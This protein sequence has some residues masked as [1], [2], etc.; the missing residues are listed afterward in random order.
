VSRRYRGDMLLAAASDTKWPSADVTCDVTRDRGCDVTA[1]V[2]RPRKPFRRPWQGLPGC[3]VLGRVSRL[4]PEKC[5]A[6]SDTMACGCSSWVAHQGCGDPPYPRRSCSVAVCPRDK[7]GP[8][9][10]ALLL[11]GR[12][13]TLRWAWSGH[14][15]ADSIGAERR[16]GKARRWGGCR[17]ARR[18][19][20][21]SRETPRETSSVT[22]QAPCKPLRRGGSEGPNPG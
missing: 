1:N 5:V 10:R 14:G 13:C 18:P 3:R 6:S 15:D 7:P 19:R 8:P 16:R 21:L 2:T 17:E 20:D 9:R 12:P 11:S 4:E 22:T